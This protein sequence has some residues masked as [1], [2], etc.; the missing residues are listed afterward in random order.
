MRP[1]AS[2]TMP[3]GGRKADVSRSRPQGRLSGR[4]QDCRLCGFHCPIVGRLGPLG[5]AVGRIT[6]L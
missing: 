1:P 3:A 5:P 6:H 2:Q 4:D